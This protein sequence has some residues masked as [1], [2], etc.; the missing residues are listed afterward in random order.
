M[1]ILVEL[2]KL[3]QRDAA[4][5]TWTVRH[6]AVE[7]GKEVAGC[8]SRGRPG[9]R[10]SPV[11]CPE[12][13]LHKGS[14]ALWCSRT[15][16][17]NLLSQEKLVTEKLKEKE[18]A[19]VARVELWVVVLVVLGVVGVNSCCPRCSFEF[20][21]VAGHNDARRHLKQPNQNTGRRHRPGN[22]SKRAPPSAAQGDGEPSVALG[23][24]D[25]NGASSATKL[26][27][28]KRCEICFQCTQF[29]E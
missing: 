24:L 28:L 16:D 14:L 15:S 20:P 3:V 18:V 12:Q 23:R 9:N 10:W 8:R 4:R 17:R 7:E 22:G 26:L 1:P 5:G 21:L 27:G 19:H 25:L 2:L 29:T 11:G 13:C 6:C